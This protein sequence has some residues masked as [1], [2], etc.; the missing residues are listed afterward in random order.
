MHLPGGSPQGHRHLQDPGIPGLD[1]GNSIYY[2]PYLELCD[3]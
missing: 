1:Q 3:S 2:Q